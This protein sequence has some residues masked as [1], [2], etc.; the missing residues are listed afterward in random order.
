MYIYIYLHIHTVCMVYT[1]I[2]YNEVCKPV[3]NH[4]VRRNILVQCTLLLKWTL[5]AAPSGESQGVSWSYVFLVSHVRWKKSES[6]V[7]RWLIPLFIS[8]D[9]FKGKF[10]RKTPYLMGKSMV[11]G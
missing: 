11:S 2:I 9:W 4:S 10:H 8:M 1:Y 7:N 6:P 5:I 3:V